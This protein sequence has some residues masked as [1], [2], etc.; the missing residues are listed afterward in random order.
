[1]I[2]CHINTE[3]RSCWSVVEL[4]SKRLTLRDEQD[5]Q[6]GQDGGHQNPNLVA[7]SDCHLRD[8]MLKH[9]SVRSNGHHVLIGQLTLDDKNHQ[10][11][12]R[13][14]KLKSFLFIFNVVKKW[15][16]LSTGYQLVRKDL[17]NK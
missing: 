13:F 11:I 12:I 8:E 6:T 16:T 1:M 4:I 7:E 9:S 17:R 5:H 15:L 10:K 3:I 2:D 14:H